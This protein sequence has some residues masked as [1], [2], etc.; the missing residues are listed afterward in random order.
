[1]IPFL[2]AYIRWAPWRLGKRVLWMRV[3][4]PRA[5]QPRA[6]VART[7]YG[8]RIAGDQRSIMPRCIYWF[9][10]WEPALS[11]WIRRAL[12]PGDVFVDVGANFGYFTLLAA[13]AV[14]PCGS[15]VAV[16]ASPSTTRRLERTVA[17]NGVENVRV[18]CAAAAAER[19]SIPFYR[20]PWNDAEDSTVPGGG[21]ERVGEVE[22]LPLPELLTELE[23]RRAR[24]IKID[25]EGGELDVLR[26]LAPAAEA[27]R[28]DAEII[29]E[30]HAD[31][32]A[33]Q[34][35]S[36]SDLIALLR[37]AGFVARELPVDTSELGHLFPE[38][39]ESTPPAAAEA[40]LRHLIFSRAGGRASAAVI[41]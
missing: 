30:A 25:V 39:V 18:V 19:G 9:G 1:M 10:V 37:P 16:E 11:D 26:G 3:A 40:S 17:R 6:F 36:V 33:A 29:V 27:L 24:L 21:V 22:A 5:S 23:L 35:A 32:L 38:H 31:K 34:G 28:P 20:A 41:L 14:G 13:R 2:R 12:R 7:R 8:F 4:E 15:V